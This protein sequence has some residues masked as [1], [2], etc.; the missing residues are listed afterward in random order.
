MIPSDTLPASVKNGAFSLFAAILASLALVLSAG[1]NPSPA[2]AAIS[3]QTITF[4]NA[5]VVNAQLNG[6]YPA[7]L[8]DWGTGVWFV[9]RATGK[10]QTRNLRFNTSSA[11]SG[12]FAFLVPRRVV[13]IA[14]FNRGTSATTVS[15]SCSGQSVASVSVGANAVGTLTTGWKANCSP[16]TISAGNG[17][18]TRFDDL[19]VDD[20]SGVLPVAADNAYTVGQGTVLTVPV[21]SGVLANDTPGTGGTMT[22][23]RVT[24][25]NSGRLT[26]RSDGS[27]T[28]TP[29]STFVGTAKFTYKARNSAGDSNVATVS[30]TVTPAA[31]TPPVAANDFYA[32][33]QGVPL[34]VP[35]A[36][37]VLTNDTAGTGGAMTAVLVANVTGVNTLTL[38][39]DGSFDYTPQSS[40]VGTDSFTYRVHNANGDSNIA[41]VTITVTA[42]ASFWIPPANTSWDWQLSTPINPS[43]NVMMYDIDMFTNDASVIASL[44]AQGRKVICYVD[45]GSWENWRPDAA[46]F[47]ASVLGSVYSGFPDER[48]LDVRAW[49]I[50]GP[51]MTARF[52][53]AKSKVCDGIEPD[54]VDGYD[55]T[56]HDPSGFPLTFNDQIAYNTQLAN[57]AH[58]LGMSIGLKNDINQTAALQ[59]VFDWALSEQCFQYGECGFFAPFTQAGKAVFEVEYKLAPS[60][61]CPQANALNFNAIQ[62]HNALD[63]YRVACR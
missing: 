48:W 12:S 32:S 41:T 43:A 55:A 20:A 47:P 16:V 53:L 61:F 33:N 13:S 28:Y 7:G 63:A 54:N 51:I 5:S 31:P 9:A 18:T 19:V 59:P 39:P 34:T 57:L 37:G 24:N 36:G 46:S 4:N 52:T 38:N 2:A 3:Q 50:L 25:V 26:L 17:Q 40:F 1:V 56:A 42:P 45:V 30:I 14:A 62:K 22:A 23:V 35:A 10:F 8:V 58:S 6:Q 49:N 44:H 27:L 21:A 60:A 29:T 15:L 11:T